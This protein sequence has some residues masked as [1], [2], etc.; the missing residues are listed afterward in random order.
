MN[1]KQ[2][3]TY[4][5]TPYIE[6]YSYTI[7][8]GGGKSI[9]LTTVQYI[10]FVLFF[11][12]MWK[13]CLVKRKRA[14]VKLA[15]VGAVAVNPA[16][17]AEPVRRLVFTEA[18]AP[19]GET[20]GTYTTA[21]LSTLPA[22]TMPQPTA[23][24]AQSPDTYTAAEVYA[25]PATIAPQ[26]TATSATKVDSATTTASPLPPTDGAMYSGMTVSND[27]GAVG[28]FSATPAAT[29]HTAYATGYGNNN[30]NTTSTTPRLAVTATAVGASNPERQIR[31]VSLAQG[32]ASTGSAAATPFSSSLQT[33]SAQ[34]ADPTKAPTSQ[35]YDYAPTTAS[36]TASATSPFGSS[37]QATSAQPAD[38]TT[39]PTYG[40]ASTTASATSPFSSSAQGAATTSPFS[41]G[42]APMASTSLY[43]SNTPAASSMSPF[44]TTTTT[45]TS[46][47]GASP[48][49]TTT[50]TATSSVFGAGTDNSTTL[51][52]N[53]EGNNT[54]TG[55]G[56]S[57]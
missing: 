33:T 16:E 41:Y 30:F 26:P 3:R 21:E 54:D 29:S 24:S 18:G 37:L 25:L 12:S 6:G 4:S 20:T 49:P 17:P 48:D 47:F 5:P 28:T 1:L 50:T 2:E 57:F 40:Y 42:S 7:M 19:G 14:R 32:T 39:A 22:T 43:G 8:R 23:T 53:A 55:Y 13:H 45:P 15:Q 51:D 9:S 52:S 36:G 34:P 27:M 44:Q 38:P 56:F 46:P 11:V 35:A 31:A 10:L